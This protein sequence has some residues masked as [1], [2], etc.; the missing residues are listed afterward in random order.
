MAV[1]AGRYGGRSAAERAADRRERLLD[2]TLA[3]WGED[4]GPRVTMTRVCAE[5]GLTE[6]YFYQEF[7]NLDAALVAVLDR[8]G[9]EID[10]RG[11]AAVEEAGD[12]PVA[13]VRAAVGAFV[14]ILTDDP[15]KGRVAIVEAVALDAVRPRRAELLRLFA[16]LA[17]EEAAELYPE[18]A[19]TAHE[20]EM[21]GLLFI[22]GVAQLVTGWLDGTLEASPEEIVGAA[23]HAFTALAHR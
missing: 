1:K 23:S 21:V 12:D 3:V 17:G 9:T 22:G 11:R 19:W 4:G 7:A 10:E 20:R 13:R 6:R 15:R 18:E 14:A 2:A 8:V 16:H 5:A